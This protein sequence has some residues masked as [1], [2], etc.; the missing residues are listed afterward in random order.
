[1]EFIK[2]ID[3]SS[4]S[5][6]EGSKGIVWKSLKSFHMIHHWND[7]KIYLLLSKDPLWIDM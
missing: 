4:F 2:C 7:P 1:M 3:P 5:N 6:E